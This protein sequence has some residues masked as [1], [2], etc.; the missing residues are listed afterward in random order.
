MAKHEIFI[1]KYGIWTKKK[2]AWSKTMEQDQKH[3]NHVIQHME[4]VVNEQAMNLWHIKEIIYFKNL[5]YMC[6]GAWSETKDNYAH[7]SR[8]VPHGASS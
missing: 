5:Y 7:E 3:R 2:R 6:L 1:K 4:Q 8:D